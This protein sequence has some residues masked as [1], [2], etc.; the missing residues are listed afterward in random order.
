[1][2]GECE[3]DGED[4]TGDF[5]SGGDF[6]LPWFGLQLISLFGLALADLGFRDI[7]EVCVVAS[8]EDEDASTEPSKRRLR[9]AA[10]AP[11][12]LAK[13]LFI[14]VFN[15]RDVDEVG[16]EEEGVFP[17]TATEEEGD[18]DGGGTGTTDRCWTC[19]TRTFF[20]LSFPS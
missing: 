16:D 17:T 20:C 2:G 7:F 4:K 10:E 9:L 13:L 11:E 8:L 15:N 1:M 18:D 6:L 14:A 19:S 12:D 3:D 5:R